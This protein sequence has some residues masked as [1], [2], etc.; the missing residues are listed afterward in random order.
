MEHIKIENL[1]YAFKE[2]RFKL[3]KI[4][5]VINKGEFILFAGKNGSGKTTLLRHINGLIIPDKGDVYISGISVK[6]NRKKARKLAGMIF[7]DAD[8][9]I[10]G[11]TVYEDVAF[12]PENLKIKRKDINQRV[13]EALKAV[14]LTEFEHKTSYNLSGGEKRRLAIAGIL[15]MKP[16]IIIFDEPFSNLDYDGILQII[17]Q[18]KFLIK[19]KKT[20]LMA[21]HDLEKVVRYADKAVIMDNGKITAF[22]TPSE[23]SEKLTQFGLVI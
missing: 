20:I 11:E 16:E 6:K 1:T 21:T 4:N 22:G 14:G 12:G 9:Q 23:I 8:A 19:E 10:V 5:L 17:E 7:Q 3:N 18:I 13:K 15:A 2:N